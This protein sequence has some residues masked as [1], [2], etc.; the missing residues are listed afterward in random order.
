[1]FL[2]LLFESALRSDAPYPAFSTAFII[3]A[4]SAVP[5]T[6]IEFVSKLTEHEVTP[7]TFE[8][9]F[10]TLLLHAAQLIPVTLYT[11]IDASL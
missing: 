10:S 8:T 11:L 6:P 4:L 1:V 3:A 9:A 5:S 2:A 7:S